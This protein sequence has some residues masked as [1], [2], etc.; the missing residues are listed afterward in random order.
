MMELLLAAVLS[1]FPYNKV[2]L[3]F[4]FLSTQYVVVLSMGVEQIPKGLRPNSC[5]EI[6]LYDYN[7]VETI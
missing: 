7:I 2:W 5:L 3:A 1:L 4:L 6:L